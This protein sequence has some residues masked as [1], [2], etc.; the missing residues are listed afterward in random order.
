MNI[1]VLLIL[2]LL[3]GVILT[4]IQNKTEENKI[5]VFNCILLTYIIS[6]LSTIYVLIFNY[7]NM[8][9]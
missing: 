5:S 2:A 7:L 6:S 8:M 4:I 1:F 3:S 9:R